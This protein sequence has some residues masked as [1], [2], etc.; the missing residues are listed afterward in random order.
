MEHQKYLGYDS[1]ERA[2]LDAYFVGNFL[3][4][5]LHELTGHQQSGRTHLADRALS[6]RPAASLEEVDLTVLI[7]VFS[8][9]RGC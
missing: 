1:G 5:V 6:N 4:V 3:H 2:S 7:K 8:A 9:S